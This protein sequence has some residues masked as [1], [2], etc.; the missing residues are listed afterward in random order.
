MQALKC[1]S[2]TSSSGGHDLSWRGLKAVELYDPITDSWQPGPALPAALPFAGAVHHVGCPCACCPRLRALLAAGRDC[3][4]CI[5]VHATCLPAPCCR[6]RIRARNARARD[7]MQAPASWAVASCTWW[8]AACTARCW[9]GWSRAATPGPAA[10]GRARRACMPQSRLRP[11]SQQERGE[12]V[13]ACQVA[14]AAGPARACSS[15]TL[16]P[17]LHVTG[18]LYVVGGRSQVNQVVPAVEVRLTLSRSRVLRS[19]VC[20]TH[21]VLHAGVL[22][23]APHCTRPHL[24]ARSAAASHRLHCCQ[25]VPHNNNRSTALRQRRGRRCQT[26][27]SRATRTRWRRW[28]AA[29][30]RSAARQASLSTGARAH[31]RRA[32]SELLCCACTCALLCA[33]ERARVCVS[34]LSVASP[35]RAM[36]AATVFAVC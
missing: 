9:C 2:C 35:V 21:C 14:E 22:H 23:T 29:C 25:R 5:V 30:T 34:C 16:L 27:S 3:S 17:L 32:G 36:N 12:C 7:A 33:R 4:L 13:R 8:A 24:C 1:M 18:L 31:W 10:R 15:Q 6:S 20:C 28:A 26:C 11:V 19:V